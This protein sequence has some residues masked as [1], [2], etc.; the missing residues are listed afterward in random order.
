[1]EMQIS[2]LEKTIRSNINDIVSD[3]KKNN[4]KTP[5]KF[6]FT[7]TMTKSADDYLIDSIDSK[8]IYD[9]DKDA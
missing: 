8:A 7:V 2:E 1:M 3:L 9:E 4:L 6:E 5:K